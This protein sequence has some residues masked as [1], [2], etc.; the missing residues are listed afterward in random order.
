MVIDD[1]MVMMM[2]MM[3]DN[4]MVMMVMMVMMVLPVMVI[5]YVSSDFTW[6]RCPRSWYFFFFH[7]SFFH[8][9]FCFSRLCT[10]ETKIVTQISCT[11]F[12]LTVLVIQIRTDTFLGTKS[13]W[14]TF[15][16]KDSS[17]EPL[18]KSLENNTFIEVILN[19]TILYS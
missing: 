15:P 18:G 8:C 2:V 6:K 13:L 14:S 1:W 10:L 11:T 12:K 5:K 4:W 3:I 7:L 17:V 9:G 16:F 19:W